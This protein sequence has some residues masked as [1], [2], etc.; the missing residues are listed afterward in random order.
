MSLL[1]EL[2]RRLMPKLP[3]IAPSEKVE[4]VVWPISFE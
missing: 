1:Y 3:P 2:M 4:P